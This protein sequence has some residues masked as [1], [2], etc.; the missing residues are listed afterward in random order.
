MGF[1]N[2]KCSAIYFINFGVLKLPQFHF[3]LS[4]FFYKK[5]IKQK[6]SKWK[7]PAQG[8]AGRNGPP[9]T[10]GSQPFPLLSLLCMTHTQEACPPSVAVAF[11]RGEEHRNHR[12]H[13]L[14]LPHKKAAPSP[15][16]S[17]RLPIHLLSSFLPTTAALLCSLPDPIS[18]SLC[19][20]LKKISEE[21]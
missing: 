10:P 20:S 5:I 7:K 4:L 15:P 11:Q 17:Q 18:T 8:E 1:S 13:L 2:S 6:N 19:T 3:F 16:P 21:K 12:A 9:T 14:L